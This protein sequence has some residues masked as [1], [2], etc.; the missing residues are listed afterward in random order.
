MRRDDA[1]AARVIVL[2][3]RLQCYFGDACAIVLAVSLCCDSGERRGHGERVLIL[4]G[5]QY[6]T[7]A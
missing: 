6:V 4:A 3:M 5:A 2:A 1:A 7:R